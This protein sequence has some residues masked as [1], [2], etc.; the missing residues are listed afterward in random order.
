VWC[1][2]GKEG[3]EER[4]VHISRSSEKAEYS[5]D[6][7]VD[8]SDLLSADTENMHASALL[9]LLIA[10]MCLDFQSHCISVSGFE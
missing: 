7:K 1:K 3:L 8:V 4:G 2:E 5:C 10:D 9:V 6:G